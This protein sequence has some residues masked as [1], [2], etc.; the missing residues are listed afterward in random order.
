MSCSL[1]VNWG[2]SKTENSMVYIYI[3]GERR[4]GKDEL[5]YNNFNTVTLLLAFFK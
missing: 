1:M 3:D 5:L 4:E 2:L